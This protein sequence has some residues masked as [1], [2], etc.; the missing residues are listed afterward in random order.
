MNALISYVLP[1]KGL[2]TGTHQFSFEVD[3]SFVDQFEDSPVPDAK[4]QV[5][6]E[7]DKR[8]TMMV[9]DFSLQGTVES[10]CDRCLATIQLPIQGNQ[11]LV[12]KYSETEQEEDADVIYIHPEQSELNVAH[13]VYECMVL[14]IPIIKAYE[15]CDLEDNPPC[16][17]EMLDRLDENALYDVDEEDETTQEER[18]DFEQLPSPWDELKNWKDRLN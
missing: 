16:D 1:I 9:L 15:D 3:K 8:S 6:L 13:Y 18:G 7:M 5:Q 4:V 14:S 12:V 11:Q 2:R 10:T 17:F